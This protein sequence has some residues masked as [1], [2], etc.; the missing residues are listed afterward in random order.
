[1]PTSCLPSVHFNPPRLLQLTRVR[2][3]RQPVPTPTSR[4]KRRS[5]PHHQHENFEKVR[6]HHYCARPAAATL[7]SS[8]P[9]CSIQD[10][11]AGVQG[12][13]RPLASVPDGRLPTCVCHWTPTTAF[14]GHRHVPSAAKQH[15]FWRLLIRCCWTSSM[16][17][18]LSTQLP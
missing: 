10:R 17:N 12:T 4:S 3:Q 11:R 15:T 7:A 13:A 1:M 8:L 16:V 5:R 9:T 14:A 18:N 6:A 2:D